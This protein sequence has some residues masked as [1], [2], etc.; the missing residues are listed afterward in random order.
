MYQAGSVHW[1]I[2][3]ERWDDWVTSYVRVTIGTG[4]LFLESPLPDYPGR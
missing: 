1:K 2:V 4:L 3:G